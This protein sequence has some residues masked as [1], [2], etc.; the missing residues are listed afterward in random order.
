[1]TPAIQDGDIGE[2]ADAGIELT[3]CPLPVDFPVAP[4]N[5]P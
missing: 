1:M 5:P 2:G 3:S 4:V